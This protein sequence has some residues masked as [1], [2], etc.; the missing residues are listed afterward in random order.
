[1]SKRQFKP[2]LIPTIVTL[3]MLP[4]LVRLGFWQIDRAK[5]KEQIQTMYEQRA[6]LPAIDITQRITDN[7]ESI[8]YRRVVVTG[9]FDVKHQILLD[10][11][12]HD[13]VVGYEVLTPLIISA[14]K[15]VLV[16]RGWIAGSADRRILPKYE[17]PTGRQK[18]NGVISIP[19]SKLIHFSDYNRDASRWPAVYQ[20]I[21]FKDM[22][23]AT[24]L[25]LLPFTIREDPK[26]PHGFVREWAKVNLLPERSESYA[27]QWFVMA[28]VLL[29]IYIGVNYKK[30][31]PDSDE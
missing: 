29:G 3:I 2:G 24:K 23:Q 11:K 31:G 6:Q 20:W 25:P 19:S 7:I 1:M 4:I 30:V 15:A 13:Q 27:V 8:H 12:V 17:T 22:R 5:E 16:N 28:F 21:D 26:G 9:K 10:N 14:T 18:I